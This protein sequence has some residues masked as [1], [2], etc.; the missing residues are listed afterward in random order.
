MAGSRRID[1]PRIPKRATKTMKRTVRIT[2]NDQKQGERSPTH[3]CILL[4]FGKRRASGE[5][6]PG[7]AQSQERRSRGLR[8]FVCVLVGEVLPDIVL[9]TG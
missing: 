8:L 6:G 4:S 9:L 3:V 7:E 2:I 1:A 5:P